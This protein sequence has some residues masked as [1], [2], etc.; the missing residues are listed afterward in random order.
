MQTRRGLRR[1]GVECAASSRETKEVGAKEKVGDGFKKKAF[2][3]RLARI[4]VGLANDGQ[5]EWKEGWNSKIRADLWAQVM[6]VVDFSRSL[7]GARSRS[8]RRRRRCGL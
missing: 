6:W 2:F 5:H 1:S 4:L 8:R 7:I 3:R